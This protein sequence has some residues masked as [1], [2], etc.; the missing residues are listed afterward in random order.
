[1]NPDEFY[2]YI[3]Y[4]SIKDGVIVNMTVMEFLEQYAHIK[5]R[6]K[7]EWIDK[8]FKWGTETEDYGQFDFNSVFMSQDALVMISKEYN[9][10]YMSIIKT[11]YLN[12]KLIVKSQFIEE[13]E[14]FR[15]RILS[16]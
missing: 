1:M 10:D 13:V 5:C 3:F 7:Y 8:G 4:T 11:T 2:V 6:F 9:W 14:E 15:N 16:S 12:T